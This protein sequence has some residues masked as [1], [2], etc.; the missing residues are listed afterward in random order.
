MLGL[1]S[2]GATVLYEDESCQGGVEN[3][4]PVIGKH[5][6]GITVWRVAPL[7]AEISLPGAM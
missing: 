5:W 3:I 1:S 4:G 7:D 6:P 2:D